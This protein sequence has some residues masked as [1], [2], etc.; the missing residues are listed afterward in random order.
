MSN[1]T[2][3][4]I[5]EDDAALVKIYKNKLQ[6]EGYNTIISL[7]GKNGLEM[8]NA[9]KPDI[10]LLDILLPK[11][12]GREVLK[13]LK[14]NSQTSSIPVLILSNLAEMDEVMKGLEEGAADY[15]IKSEHSLEEVV[16]RIKSIL[17]S[18]NQPEKEKKEEIPKENTE[19]EKKP[20]QNEN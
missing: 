18:N 1:T 19:Q 4:L 14:E 7:N 12:N 17:N 6:R 2:K 16:E 3:I 10:I 13:K 8:A 20:E 15:M 9:E 5:I 11:L